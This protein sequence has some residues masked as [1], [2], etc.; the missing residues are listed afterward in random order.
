MK[1]DHFNYTL[2]Q[3]EQSMKTHNSNIITQTWYETIK[4]VFFISIN[5]RKNAIYKQQKVIM[6]ICCAVFVELDQTSSSEFWVFLFTSLWT[7]PHP[8]SPQIRGTWSM[9]TSI[10]CALISLFWIIITNI[11]LDL[12]DYWLSRKLYWLYTENW[13]TIGLSYWQPFNNVILWEYSDLL[14]NCHKYYLYH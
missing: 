3:K 8:P 14:K 11:K 4:D 1:I 10:Y 2:T 7:H 6:W 13:T 12:S 5:S 9:S